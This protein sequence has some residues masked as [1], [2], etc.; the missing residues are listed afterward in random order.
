[1]NRYK[2]LREDHVC[3]HHEEQG[4]HCKMEGLLKLVEAEDVECSAGGHSREGG[5]H[6][7]A[8]EAFERASSVPFRAW[9]GLSLLHCLHIDRDV[10]KVYALSDPRV[11]GEAVPSAGAS[12]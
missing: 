5:H 4:V 2:V 11:R 7:E 8:K 6:H 12:T 3:G 1:M 9:L 10:S